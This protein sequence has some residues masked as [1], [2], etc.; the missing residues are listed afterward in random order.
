ML[1]ALLGFLIGAGIGYMVHRWWALVFA[2]F[3]PA[4]I[5][6]GVAIGLWGNGFGENWA[7]AIP[8]WVVPAAL[9]YFLGWI[10]SSHQSKKTPLFRP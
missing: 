2:V 9:G 1:F 8:I 10:A 5:Y 7:Y 4:P 3:L 6:L